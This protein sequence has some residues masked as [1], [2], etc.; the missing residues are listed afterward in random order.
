VGSQEIFMNLENLNITI[1]IV[2]GITSLFLAFLNIYQFF[3][4][5]SEVK[6]KEFLLT[7]WHNMTEGIKHALLQIAQNPQ[8]FTDKQ[9]IVNSVNVVAQ[10]ATSMAQAMEEQRF[11]STKEVLQ[12]RQEKQRKFEDQ[13]RALKKQF[14]SNK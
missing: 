11:F 3:N 9:D 13:M 7:N 4:N 8:S 5:E 6:T 12:N 2:L 14:S 10:V 1:S